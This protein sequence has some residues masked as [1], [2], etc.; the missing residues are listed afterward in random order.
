MLHHIAGHRWF[1]IIL[2]S[3]RNDR[4]T[5][6][7]TQLILLRGARLDVCLCDSPSF[8]FRLEREFDPCFFNANSTVRPT[9]SPTVMSGDVLR[10]KP[11][12]WVQ[13]RLHFHLCRVLFR[14]F[15]RRRNAARFLLFQSTRCVFGF[16]LFL[17]CLP[18]RKRRALSCRLSVISE[19][20]IV[21]T[22][23]LSDV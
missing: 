3:N 10:A 4:T 14:P 20:T 8:R 22:D 11:A 21:V 5:F 17:F 15:F 6:C 19:K 2:L 7:S 16:C 13:C 18:R 12:R 1:F 9:L 23:M